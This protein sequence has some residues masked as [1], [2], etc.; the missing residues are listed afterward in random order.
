M[1]HAAS[2]TAPY[3]RHLPTQ[4]TATSHAGRRCEVGGRP[5]GPARRRRIAGDLLAALALAGLLGLIL[6]VAVGI[7]LG[8]VA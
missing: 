8:G 3:P 4:R 1:N 6:A 5:I 2:R 7:A